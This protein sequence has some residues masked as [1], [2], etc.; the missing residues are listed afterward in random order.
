MAGSI[1][2]GQLIKQDKI[3]KLQRFARPFFLTVLPAIALAQ[4]VEGAIFS[5][6]GVW[7]TYSGKN[8]LQLAKP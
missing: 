7:N 3:K 2:D 5:E 8:N 1:G 4:A 6:A